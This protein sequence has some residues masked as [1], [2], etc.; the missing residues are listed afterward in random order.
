[1]NPAHDG[2][3]VLTA[4]ESEGHVDKAVQAA[5]HA[6]TAWR[7]GGL[8]ARISAL[9]AVQARVEDHA[10]G[11]AE[12]ITLEMGKPIREARIEAR[13][14]AGKIEGVIKQLAHELPAAA[15]GAPGEQRFHALGVVAIIG[16]FNFPVH[17]LNTHVIPA[18]LTG[19]AVVIKPSE[20]TPLCGQR[21]AELFHDAGFPRGIFNMV[22][23]L[24]ATGQAL[25]THEG[26]DGVVFTGS[27]AT[28]RR[29]R[30]ATFD[31][32][33][34]K[35]S[36]ELGGK[37]PAVVL[38]DAD[39]DQATREILLGALL[40]TGQRCT[41]TSRVIA[42]PGIADELRARL[43]TAFSRASR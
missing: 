11:I 1:M 14:I 38:D 34:K 28:G 39:I 4:I 2:Q 37:D 35:I 24:G 3:V 16:P 26:T 9:R 42:T 40:T 15:P 30:E 10:E 8:D 17:L 21:Y 43:K 12:A 22:H 41:A 5:R 29:I 19:N 31:L 27:Y 18:L 25:V 23:G 6:A 13:S 32:P 7:R 20:V 33:A 36:L